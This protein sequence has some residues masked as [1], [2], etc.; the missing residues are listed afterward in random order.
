MVITTALRS[1][2]A[3]AAVD[4]IDSGGGTA[5]LAIYTGSAPGPDNAA[6]GT[7]LAEFDLPNPAFGAASSGVATANAISDTTGLASGT[8]GYFRV[9]NRGGTAVWEG[10]VGVGSGELQLNT[11]SISSGVTVSIT[12]WTVTMPA[13]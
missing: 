11:L 2:L 13:S 9:V 3:D 5:K 8:A 4:N 12:S 1:I 7:K 6:T 10:T